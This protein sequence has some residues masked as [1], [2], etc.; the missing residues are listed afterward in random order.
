MRFNFQLT[1]PANTTV[2]SPVLARAKLAKG[3]LVT[4]RIKFEAGCH[5]QVK[6]MV[7]DRLFQI[8]PA[9]GDTPMF[10]DNVAFRIPMNYPLKDPPYELTLFGWSPSTKYAHTITFSFDLEPAEGATDRSI[11]EVMFGP[12][13]DVIPR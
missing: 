13:K 10:G 8:L 5:N 6:V 9:A 3:T 12:M 2:N 1:V 7:R 11:L 4:A